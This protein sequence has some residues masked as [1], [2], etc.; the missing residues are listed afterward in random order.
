MKIT[1]T[2]FVHYDGSK[3]FPADWSRWELYRF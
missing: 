2:V 1:Q 3:Y